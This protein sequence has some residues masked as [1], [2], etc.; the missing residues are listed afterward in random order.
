MQAGRVLSNRAIVIAAVL[1]VLLA[2][3]TAWLLLTRY[4]AGTDSDKA[5]LEAVR[6]VGTIVL[7][8]GG[9]IAL[10]LAARRQQTAERDLV[11]KRLDL[12]LKQ[13]AQDY[14]ERDATSRR[15]TDLYDKAVDQLG[16]DK[17]PVRLG[18]LYALERLAQDNADPSL[19]QTIVN[20]ICAYLRMPYTVP[21]DVLPEGADADSRARHEQ[22]VQERQVRL[23]AQRILL[24]HLR[25]GD[26]II[27]VDKFWK[28]IDLDLSEATL[29]SFR[30]DQA[31]L[32][33]AT[34]K[35]AHFFG[36][37]QFSQVNF[38][39]GAIFERAVFT[40]SAHLRNATFA[41]VA[42]FSGTTFHG[43]CDF[44]KARFRGTSNFADACF[45]EHVTFRNARFSD[46]GNFVRANFD[47]GVAFG[48]KFKYG[49]VLDGAIVTGRTTF[50][51]AVI[52]DI[53]SYNETEFRGP[54]ILGNAR[55]EHDIPTQ[56][57]EWCENTA[58]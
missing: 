37:S 2:V 13:R 33:Y 22:G 23:A 5:Q 41:G 14:T 52:D 47:C 17:A 21:Q 16:S 12:Q 36:E 10:L 18:G 51:N 57:L 40:A 55:F 46:T 45:E 35:G 29:I 31:R 15:I 28:D 34:F 32:R 50:S 1:V 24:T 26:D 56:W 39:D 58:D 42:W 3:V 30:L 54:L 6:V 8:A 20:V 48:A 38:T 43:Y 25:P 44:G 4:G 27:P 49:I 7:G 9:A 53:V 19:R 11:E